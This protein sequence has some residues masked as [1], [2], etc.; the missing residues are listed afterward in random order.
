MQWYQ[1]HFNFNSNKN[2]SMQN[3]I[4]KIDVINVKSLRQV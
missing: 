1:C 2:N 4:H 3:Y